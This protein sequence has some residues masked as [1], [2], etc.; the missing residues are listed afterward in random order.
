MVPDHL[1][2]CRK[3]SGS[4]EA[5]LGMQ[6]YVYTLGNIVGSQCRN[7]NSQVDAHPVVEFHGS[8]ASDPVPKDFL[9]ATG[10]V[11]SHG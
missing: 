1:L 9:G 5:I 4:K 10:Y 2:W 8:P 3:W 7:A 6:V 11:A